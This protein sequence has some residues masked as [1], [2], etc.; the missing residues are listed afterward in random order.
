[1]YNRIDVEDYLTPSQIKF[2]TPYYFLIY[3]PN[4]NKIDNS[5]LLNNKCEIYF[6][7]H[8]NK[9]IFYGGIICQIKLPY[10]ISKT[11]L[12]TIN[13]SVLKYSIFFKRIINTKRETK[14]AYL[15]DI[16]NGLE[17]GFITIS[18]KK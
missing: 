2:L 13:L 9:K 17:S 14:N 5:K 15:E 6:F 18:K 16:L 1:M 12:Q 8:F 7:N 10:I 11:K 4:N 3:E